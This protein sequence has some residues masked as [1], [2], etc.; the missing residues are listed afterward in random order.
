MVAVAATTEVADP[1]TTAASSTA[2]PT[3]A[4]LYFSVLVFAGTIGVLHEVAGRQLELYIAEDPAHRTAV[5]LIAA[6]ALI[7]ALYGSRKLSDPERWL[8]WLLVATSVV[9][10]ASGFA[11]FFSFTS[12]IGH[13]T[14]AFVVPILS[15]A[16]IGSLV[17][18]FWRSLG[19]LVVGLGVFVRM[20]SPF[21]LLAL[22]AG[23]G[24]ASI[25]ATQ[26]G[27]LRSGLVVALGLA[28]A[29]T[30]LPALLRHLDPP[31]APALRWVRPTALA[32]FAVELGLFGAAEWCVPTTMLSHYDNEVVYAAET[33]R[34]E[35]V[36]TSGQRTFELFVDGRLD[37]TGI[38]EDRYHEALVHPALEVASS[39]ANVLLLGGGDGMA[40]REILKHADV[41]RI[42]VVTVDAELA[43]LARTVP[44]LD[45]LSRGAMRSD[46]VEVIEREPIA[47][48]SESVDLYDVAIVDLPDPD[49]F[50]QGKNYTRRFYELLTGRLAPAGVACVQAVSPFGTP[51]T[52]ASIVATI[53]AAGLEA[54][55]YRAP[56][57]TFGEWGFVL[58]SRGGITAPTSAR[59]GS[60]LTPTTISDMFAMPS[61]TQAEVGATP[62]TLSDQRVVITFEE[63]RD[64]L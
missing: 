63:E 6:S 17:G 40:E 19:R 32:L 5:R 25:A 33:D 41:Q 31:R 9:A 48:L 14:T 11:A 59:H 28:L 44:W 29:A 57:P 21:R 56:I 8:S 64:A 2:D 42:T 46:R 38:D 36:F 52:F 62:S 34:R 20:L 15:A 47:W 7:A 61:D 43:R 23:L 58:A 16:L 1:D 37:V 26:I 13:R 22:T 51:R 35:Y 50:V 49:G 30:W 55:P 45:S 24:A 12:H 54:L 3:R 4:L 27:P 18:V 53:R 39:R 60:F 10:A